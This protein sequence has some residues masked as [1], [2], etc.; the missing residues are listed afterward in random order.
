MHI[1]SS[2]AGGGGVSL[3]ILRDLMRMGGVGS[4]GQQVPSDGE[5]VG[6]SDPPDTPP[7]GTPPSGS[8]LASAT[9]ASL[10]Q[11]QEHKPSASDLAGKILSAADTDGDGSLSLD[12]V[13]SALSKSQK[14]KTASLSDA[15]NSVDSDGDGKLSADEL[16]SGLQTMMEARH[17]HHGHGHAYAY[18]RVGQSASTNTASTSTTPATTGTT[19]ETTGTTETTETPPPVDATV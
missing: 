4:T 14:G 9:L 5:A 10:L 1:S 12:E 17:H 11:F 8:T 6:N 16:A 15:F 19:P 3:H 2:A 7:P 13:T 18:G